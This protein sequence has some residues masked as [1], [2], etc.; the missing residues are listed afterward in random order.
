KAHVRVEVLI[1]KLPKRGWQAANIFTYL[2]ALV[3][4]GL[5]VYGAVLEALFSFSGREA[6]SSIV[7]LPMYPVKFIIVIGVAFYLIQLLINT[8]KEFKQPM[9]KPTEAEM[10]AEVE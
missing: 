8:T 4:V 3:V 2:V 1:S 10:E 5:L 6:M 9:L 7:L